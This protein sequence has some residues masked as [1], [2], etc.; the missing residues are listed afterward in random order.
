MYA[1]LLKDMYDKNPEKTIE[2]YAKFLECND[3]LSLDES[4]KVLFD[5]KNMITENVVKNFVESLDKK[6]E[7]MI[8]KQETK[9]M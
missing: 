3:S 8:D 4:S 9:S 2:Q 5:D 7:K 6:T 1:Y